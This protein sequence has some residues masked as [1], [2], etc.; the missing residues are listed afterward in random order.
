MLLT[1]IKFYLFSNLCSSIT[2]KS[3]FYSFYLLCWKSM[4]KTS[5]LCLTLI[6]KLRYSCINLIDKSLLCAVIHKLLIF[7]IDISK[8][9][10]NQFVIEEEEKTEEIIIGNLIFYWNIY[11]LFLAVD[12]Y[13]S[14][15][16]SNCLFKRK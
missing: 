1:T 7:C 14:T 13:Y 15:I 3:Y 11:C 8:L 16:V 6:W 2:F 9:P 10:Q 5:N 4:K 12:F